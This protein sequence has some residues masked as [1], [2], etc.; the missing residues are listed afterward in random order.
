MDF[1]ANITSHCLQLEHGVKN[2]ILYKSLFN[3]E[4]NVVIISVEVA[5]IMQKVNCQSWRFQQCNWLPSLQRRASSFS[6]HLCH[7]QPQ[8]ISVDDF[9]QVMHLLILNR[10]CFDSHKKIH[11]V[12]HTPRYLD[13]TSAFVF[14]QLI[15][16][17]MVLQ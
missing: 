16:Y 2:Y 11:P 1:D 6:T 12:H 7:K 15:Q 14:C 13:T 3:L 4:M 9:F 17:L 5:Q 10:L 8:Y